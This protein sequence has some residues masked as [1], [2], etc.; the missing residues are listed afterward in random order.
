MSEHRKNKR[1]SCAVPVDGKKGSPFGQIKTIDISKGGVGFISSQRIPLH[2]RI[3]LELVLSEGDEPV[4]AIGE[5][6]WVR[7][8]ANSGSYRIGLAFEDIKNG[9]KSRLIDY[10]RE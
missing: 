10:F 7:P 8:I 2:K 5:V 6:K 4:L 1:I 9:S 3:A